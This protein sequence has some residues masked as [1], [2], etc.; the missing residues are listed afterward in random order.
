MRIPVPPKIQRVPCAM[1]RAWA[2]CRRAVASVALSTGPHEYHAQRPKRS[3]AHWPGSVQPRVNPPAAWTNAVAIQ[4][5]HR[6]RGS[7]ISEAPTSRAVNENTETSG[8]FQETVLLAVN[9]DWVLHGLH[10][11]QMVLGTAGTTMFK[12]VAELQL[13]EYLSY[14]IHNYQP[15]TMWFEENALL[16]LRKLRLKYGG[17][18]TVF[19]LLQIVPSDLYLI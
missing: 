16:V 19:Y 17:P 8:V 14:S 2:M 4:N 7:R 11:W 15:R 13:S 12:L 18:S 9:T 6:S 3:L 10:S 5:Q 1:W